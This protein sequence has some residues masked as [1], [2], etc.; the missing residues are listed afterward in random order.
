VATDGNPAAT[1][2]SINIKGLAVV[3]KV[4]KKTPLTRAHARSRAREW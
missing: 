3:A 2:T 1:K 4:A